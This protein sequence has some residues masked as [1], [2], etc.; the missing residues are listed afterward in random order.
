MGNEFGPLPFVIGVTGHR[1][2]RPEDVESLKTAV[3]KIID[4]LHEQMPNTPLVVLSALADG[5]DRLVASV[6][7]EKKLKV[8]VPLPMKQGEYENDFDAASGKEFR[9]LL[10]QIGITNKFELPVIEGIAADKDKM[11]NL[12]YAQVGQYI[13]LH[14]HLMIALWD[15]LDPE[16]VGGTAD[17]VKMCLSEGR[18]EEL[19]SGSSWLNYEDECGPVY[20]ILTPRARSSAKQCC[21]PDLDQLVI[22]RDAKKTKMIYPKGKEAT[23]VANW[24]STDRFNRDC[25]RRRVVIEQNRTSSLKT[26]KK[27]DVHELESKGTLAHV[28][29]AADQLALKMKS[30]WEKRVFGLH[31]TVVFSILFFGAI[32]NLEPLMNTDKVFWEKSLWLSFFLSSF[33]AFSIWAITTWRKIQNRFLDYRGLAEALRIQFNWNVAGIQGVEVA[34]CYLRYQL[35]KLSWVRAAVRVC[36]IGQGVVSSINAEKRIRSVFENWVKEQRNYYD[37]VTPKRDKKSSYLSRWGIVWVLFGMGCAVLMLHHTIG[38]QSLGVYSCLVKM[39]ANAMFGVA[40]VIVGYSG[41]LAIEEESRQF[42]RMRT[43]YDRA[44]KLRARFVPDDDGASV[45]I[46]K[47]RKIIVELGKEALEENGD[48]I[49]MHRSHPLDYPQRKTEFRILVRAMKMLA[50]W[51][52]SFTKSSHAQ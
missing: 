10:A 7:L 24:Q 12:Q 52:R 41:I 47:A 46:P 17:V 43:I 31:I 36:S 29:S 39:L 35:D 38:T 25:W 45:D 51:V 40:A 11:R 6:A 5:A 18:M 14:S 3:S 49:V 42:G 9:S 48:W 28:F 34:D 16:L 22:G 13:V 23:F 32:S 8:I 21:I 27:T 20:Q 50:G 37:Q 1:D 44:D 33:A 4:G 19:S 15:G 2:L 26:F 30:V